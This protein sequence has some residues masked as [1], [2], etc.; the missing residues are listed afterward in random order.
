MSNLPH[1]LTKALPAILLVICSS[2]GFARRSGQ[3]SLSLAMADREMEIYA[4]ART[5]IDMTSD[6]LLRA[7]PDEVSDLE[8]SDS[9]EELP[10]LLRDVG[11]RVESLARDIPNTASREQVRRELLR[12]NLKVDDA[13]TQTYNYLV[14][15]GM[16]GLWEEIRTDSK[17]HPV[18]VGNT[19][20]S[21]FMTSGF[22]GVALFFHPGSQA[23]S[24]FRLLGRQRSKP[25]AY[26]IAFAQRP[27]KAQPTGR[28]KTPY[29]LAPARLMFQGLAWV[30]PRSHQILRMRTDLLAPRRDVMLARQTTEIW[31]SEVHFSSN[32]RVFWLPHEV[33]VTVEWNGQIYRN[34]HRYS[35]YLVFSVESNDKLEQPRIKK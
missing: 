11:D 19:Q 7:F 6:E 4:L 26:V 24:R 3:V 9:Q 35:D 27:E 5:V 17:G 31:F 13:S 33:L 2:L 8:F 29:M 25:N 12:E 34:R 10:V 21:Y 15:P 18:A 28:L 32:P 23:Q 22:A 16:S 1:C 30:D 14:L 20:D